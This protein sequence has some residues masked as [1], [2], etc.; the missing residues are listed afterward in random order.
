[1]K[2]IAVL[3]L[4]LLV[5]CS[6]ARPATL[7]TAPEGQQVAVASQDTHRVVS[8]P[9]AWHTALSQAFRNPSL[10]VQVGT[11]RFGPMIAAIFQDSA[12]MRRSWLEQAAAAKEVARY[13]FAHSDSTPPLGVV[14]VAYEDP[15]FEGFH[16]AHVYRFLPPAR[17]DTLA[18]AQPVR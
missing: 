14:N 6:T 10:R 4:A 13:I 18:D 15:G 12:A 1:M 2:C 8:N 11:G 16:R 5:A 7:R 9:G 17:G 3:S